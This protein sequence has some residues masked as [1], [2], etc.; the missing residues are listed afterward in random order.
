MKHGKIL[1]LG[2]AIAITTGGFVTTATPAFA[3]PQMVVQA[4]SDVP[5][6]LVRFGDLDL[7]VA[8]GRKLLHRRVASAVGEVCEGSESYATFQSD[9]F[10]RTAAW[11]RA[12]P[13]IASAIERAQLFAANGLTGSADQAIVITL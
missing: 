3:A 10:C 2:A 4:P 9:G 6:R 12:D 13:Q 5:V 8:S 11:K 1:A 7:T